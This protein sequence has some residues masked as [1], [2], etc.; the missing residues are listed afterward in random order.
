MS[1]QE[2]DLVKMRKLL[3]FESMNGGHC[4]QLGN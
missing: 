3:D 4:V 2:G 1:N